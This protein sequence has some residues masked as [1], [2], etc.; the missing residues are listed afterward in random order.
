MHIFSSSTPSYDPNSVLRGRNGLNPL[1]FDYVIKLFK[2]R[3]INPLIN[4][5]P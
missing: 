4:K 1:L 3:D 5:N 2:E